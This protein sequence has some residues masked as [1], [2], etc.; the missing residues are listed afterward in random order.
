MK[1]FNKRWPGIRKLWGAVVLG[2]S[3][4]AGVAIPQRK[5]T[6]EEN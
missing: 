4:G 6:A 5:H 2:S 1:Y 3:C